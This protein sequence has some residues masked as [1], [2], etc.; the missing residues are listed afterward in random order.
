MCRQARSLSPAA[1]MGREPEP[2]GA[3][4]GF[5]DQ[6]IRDK[7]RIRETPG[8]LVMEIEVRASDNGWLQ[9]NGRP[10][11]VRGDKAAT[12]SAA[13]VIISAHM[14]DLARRLAARREKHLRR[15]PWETRAPRHLSDGAL[16]ARSGPRQDL[17]PRVLG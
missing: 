3:R 16:R 12:W 13:N 6:S 1:R 7:A 2:G 4:W 10:A 5:T 17:L 9:V 15:T 11:T 8:G 14:V